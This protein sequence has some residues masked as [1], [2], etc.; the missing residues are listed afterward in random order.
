MKKDINEKH[1]EVGNL[2]FVIFG[3]VTSRWHTGRCTIRETQGRSFPLAVGEWLLRH[4][5]SVSW[6]M[7][8]AHREYIIKSLS[9][10]M[11]NEWIRN[12]EIPCLHPATSATYPLW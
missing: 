9:C 6:A 4:A 7:Q 12:L 1:L 8:A 11:S 3:C 2:S 5:T 10:L